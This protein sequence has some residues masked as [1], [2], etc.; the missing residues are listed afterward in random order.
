ME[1]I[2]LTLDVI[3]GKWKWAILVT[4][5]EETLRFGELKKRIPK[6]PHQSLIK[7]IKELEKDGLVHRQS[8][9]AVPPEVEYSLTTYGRSVIGLLEEMAEWGY[10]H[11]NITREKISDF[12][13]DQFSV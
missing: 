2:K 12:K 10:R 1:H 9:K 11:R 6:I 13:K 4:L 8:Y 3:C 7:Q 5:Y